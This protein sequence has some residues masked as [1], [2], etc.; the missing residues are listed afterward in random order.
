MPCSW[1][2]GFLE[3]HIWNC[4]WKISL[5]YLSWCKYYAAHWK[6]SHLSICKLLTFTVPFCFQDFGSTAFRAPSHVLDRVEKRRCR[7]SARSR[8]AAHDQ[9]R[10]GWWIGPGSERVGTTTPSAYELS[11]IVGRETTPPMSENGSIWGG[12]TA[13][14]TSKIQ[15]CAANQ[16]TRPIRFL[17]DAGKSPAPHK[18]TIVQCGEHTPHITSYFIWKW[19]VAALTPSCLVKW[20]E[21]TKWCN[22]SAFRDIN[23]WSKDDSGE[24]TPTAI[25][26]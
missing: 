19:L 23:I 1:D 18:P 7:R 16:P 25:Y 21:K 15:L 5:K 6:R 3:V 14:P 24:T 13:P 26:Y 8:C 20:D 11:S 17:T 4:N 2:I 10:V 9:D 12:L 22:R